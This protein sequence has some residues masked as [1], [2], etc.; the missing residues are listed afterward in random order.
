M[1]LPERLKRRRISCS[2]RS[3][4]GSLRVLGE[5][6]EEIVERKLGDDALVED[7]R[8]VARLGARRRAGE[9]RD[10]ESG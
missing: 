4:A 1:A 9:E 8:G 7:R 2:I 6:G 5:L 3:P 10:E